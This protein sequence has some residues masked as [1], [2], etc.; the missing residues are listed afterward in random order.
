MATEERATDGL[1][2][3][4]PFPIETEDDIVDEES[5]EED[6]LEDDPFDTINEADEQDEQS[7]RHQSN[8]SHQN[9]GKTSPVQSYAQK[10]FENKA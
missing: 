1:I 9:Q 5:T 8:R 2:I 7:A 10:L 3:V 4:Q 6:A